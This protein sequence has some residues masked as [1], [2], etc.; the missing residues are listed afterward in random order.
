MIKDEAGGCFFWGGVFIFFA[1]FLLE[2]CAALS[3]ATGSSPKRK[4]KTSEGDE[5]AVCIQKC[6]KVAK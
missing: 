2:L 3:R 5:K 1:I 6:R 4:A